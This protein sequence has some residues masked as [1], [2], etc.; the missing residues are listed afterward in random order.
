MTDLMKP[1]AL[2]FCWL[3][4]LVG[5]AA[6]SSAQDPF[7]GTYDVLATTDST[8]ANDP[9][10]KTS[11]RTTVVVSAG[12]NNQLIFSIG[13]PDAGNCLLTGTAESSTTFNMDANGQGCV[14]LGA[15][16]GIVYSQIKQ[17]SGS[18]DAAGNLALNQSGTL[19]LKIGLLTVK[20]T[21]QQAVTGSRDGG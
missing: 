15:D 3:F 6:C 13:P 17:G 10:M 16:G 5:L 8:F 18:V 11:K 19:T 14:T 12:T 4:P 1:S 2:S 7:L 20:G 9:P 21:F